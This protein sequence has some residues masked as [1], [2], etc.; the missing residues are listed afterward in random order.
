M[1]HMLCHLHHQLL[2]INCLSS[3]TGLTV[4]CTAY[5]D[6]FTHHAEPMAL[7]LQ[8]FAFLREYCPVP[9]RPR[10][11]VAPVYMMCNMRFDLTNSLIDAQC[12]TTEPLIH[13]LKVFYLYFHGMLFSTI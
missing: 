10:R 5:F 8:L 11:S 13:K 7:H 2:S 3:Y 1:N 4:C 12:L 6:R 9:C